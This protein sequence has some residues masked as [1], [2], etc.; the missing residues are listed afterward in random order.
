MSDAFHTTDPDGNSLKVTKEEYADTPLAV[1]V[2]ERRPTGGYDSA[3]AFLTVPHARQ[4]LTFLQAF[5][6]RHAPDVLPF[7]APPQ[8]PAPECHPHFRGILCDVEDVPILTLLSSDVT[9]LGDE[10][11]VELV[12]TGKGA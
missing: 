4:L 2:T 12:E 1:Q 7:P 5:L 6:D 9:D 10:V 11:N 8:P 3:V